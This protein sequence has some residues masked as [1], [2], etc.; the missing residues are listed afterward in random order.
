M[1]ILRAVLVVVV[2]RLGFGRFLVV[3]VLTVYDVAR[4]ELVHDF[5]DDLD[6]KHA[7][8]EACDQ[9]PGGFLWRGSAVYQ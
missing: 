7:S 3:R 9:D 8:E 2:M 5:A 4:H 6:A 1:A